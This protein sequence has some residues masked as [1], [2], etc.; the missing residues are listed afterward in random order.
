MLIHLV[1]VSYLGLVQPPL[2]LRLITFYT[3]FINVYTTSQVMLPSAARLMHFCKIIF[4]HYHNC[5]TYIDI[6]G[7]NLKRVYHNFM[8]YYIIVHV[9]VQ[10]F[11]FYIITQRDIPIFL[12]SHSHVVLYLHKSFM[13]YSRVT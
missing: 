1:I 4:S 12:I 8:W 5:Y 10:T 13:F 11:L 7:C 6:T 3:L 9:S 2:Q